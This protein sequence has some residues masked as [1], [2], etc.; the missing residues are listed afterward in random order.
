VVCLRDSRICAS[1][2]SGALC[3]SKR[4]LQRKLNEAMAE[5]QKSRSVGEARLSVG[6]GLL[7]VGLGL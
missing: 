6:S 1:S 2:A 3:V 5:Q 7:V 4:P